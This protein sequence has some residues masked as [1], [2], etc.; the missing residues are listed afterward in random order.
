VAN[1]TDLF[2]DGCTNKAV[3]CA[4]KARGEVGIVTPGWR[5]WH[6]AT[7]M[8]AP[9]PFSEACFA[10]DVLMPNRAG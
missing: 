2:I 9:W 4:G 8:C 10:Q 1:N 5:L 6:G 3:F 7:G